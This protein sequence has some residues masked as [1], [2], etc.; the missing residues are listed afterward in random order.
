MMKIYHFRSSHQR[1]YIK[2]GVLRISQNSE[3]NTCARAS[4]FNKVT[5]LRPATLLKKRIW[6][7]H[8]PVN[9]VKFLRTPFLIGH[10][11][12]LLLL[13]ARSIYTITKSS[14]PIFFSNNSELYIFHFDKE[15]SSDFEIKIFYFLNL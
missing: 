2:K 10:L 4:F 3:E 12:W 1:H 11:W 14:M 7:R 15:I 9:F 13:R 5:D 8:F 6:H